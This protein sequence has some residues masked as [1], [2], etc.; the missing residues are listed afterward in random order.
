MPGTNSIVSRNTNDYIFNVGLNPTM[1]IGNN[2]LAFNAGIQSTVRRDSVSPVAMNQNLFR[3]FGYVSTSSFFNTVSAQAYVIRE[4]GP[5]TDSNLHSQA[6]A[7]AIDFRVGAPWGR[8]VLVTGW[9]TSDQKFSPVNFED[10]Y[11]SSYLGLERR[12]GERLKLK[13][14][15][16]DLRAWRIVG[17]KSGLAQNLRPAGTVVFAP[18]P[19][20]NMKLSTAYSSNRSFHVYDAVQNGLSVSYARPFRRRFHD[21]S[22]AI[23]LQY[24]IRFSAGFQEETF[25]NFTGGKSQQIRPYIRISL[26]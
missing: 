12:L 2:V 10:Y 9:G 3:M 24:P 25:F 22:S 4:T 20:W 13:G 23:V 17:T 11:T 19:S 5:F 7:G 8:T 1:R 6:L 15:I 16:E 14:V 26:F 21:D 18:N